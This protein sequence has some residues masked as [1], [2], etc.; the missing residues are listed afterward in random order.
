[1]W[2]WVAVNRP[3]WPCCACLPY[4]QPYLRFAQMQAW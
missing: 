1:L 2:P 3:K 4:L